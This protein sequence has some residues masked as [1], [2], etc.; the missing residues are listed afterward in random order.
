VAT[1]TKEIVVY[2]LYGDSG[3]LLYIGVTQNWAQ[4]REHHAIVQPWFSDVAH[5]E[6]ESC[7]TRKDA[8]ARE[9]TLIRELKPRYNIQHQPL[10]PLPPVEYMEP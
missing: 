2:R 10:P 1:A 3:S 6:L 9:A 8:L 7:P 5:A 4:R